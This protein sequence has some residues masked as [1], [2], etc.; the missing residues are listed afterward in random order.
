MSLEELAAVGVTEASIR[1]AIR[2]SHRGWLYEDD[3]EIVG[4]AMGD[5]EAAELTV[6]AVLPDYE[7]RG[8]GSRLL[9]AVEA[10]LRSAGCRSIWLTT[11]IDPGLRAYGFYVRHGWTDRKKENGLRYMVKHLGR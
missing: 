10:W 11:D 8:I 2:G 3:G 6:I 7:C 9:S 1:T 5:C 4:F